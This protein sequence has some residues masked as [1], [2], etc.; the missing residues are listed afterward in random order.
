[1]IAAGA[2]TLSRAMPFVCHST[3]HFDSTS[4]KVSY[5]VPRYHTPTAK[6]SKYLFIDFSD[7]IIAAPIG[8]IQPAHFPLLFLFKQDII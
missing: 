6:K 1:M 3:P 4:R 2:D 7:F 5:S 8:S